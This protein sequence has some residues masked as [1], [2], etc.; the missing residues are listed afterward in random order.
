MQREAQAERREAQAERREA[1]RKE[2]AGIE[3][4]V[5]DLTNKLGIMRDKLPKVQAHV[6][7][8]HDL[9]VETFAAEKAQIRVLKDSEHDARRLRH[10]LDALRGAVEETRQSM[11]HAGEKHARQV[12]RWHVE[13]ERLTR[14]LGIAES[15]IAASLQTTGWAATNRTQKLATLQQ[16]TDELDAALLARKADLVRVEAEAQKAK[17]RYEDT[18]KVSACVRERACRCLLCCFFKIRLIG[19]YIVLAMFFSSSGLSRCN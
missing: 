16:E 4:T 10:D 17:V 7:H 5:K 3:T 14:E 1:R 19:K 13:E 6:N 15:I 2:K 18:C 9:L 12:R 11:V 8:S